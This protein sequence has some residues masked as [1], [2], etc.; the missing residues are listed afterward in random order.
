M[1]GATRKRLEEV[2]QEQIEVVASMASLTSAAAAAG[3][4]SA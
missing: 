4:L 1:E 2:L 3:K